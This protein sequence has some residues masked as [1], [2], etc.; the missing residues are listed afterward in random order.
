[1]YREIARRK[2][3]IIAQVCNVL[4]K[5]LTFWGIAILEFREINPL[6]NSLIN[7]YGIIIGLFIALL[8]GGLFI[9]KT[10]KVWWSVSIISIV[11]VIIVI[12]NSYQIIHYYI[13]A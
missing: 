7:F 6:V 13:G 4:D 12:I 2:S 8:I 11:Y 3:Y 1:M 5:L 10:R 9:R